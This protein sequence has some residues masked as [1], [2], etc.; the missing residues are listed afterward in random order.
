MRTDLP[1]TMCETCQP[2]ITLCAGDLHGRCGG[3][4]T[5]PVG[6]EV[7]ASRAAHRFAIYGCDPPSMSERHMSVPTTDRWPRP[8]GAFQVSGVVTTDCWPNGDLEIRVGSA[9]ALLNASRAGPEAMYRS[10]G[11]SIDPR[12]NEPSTA[13]V[14]LANYRAQTR[15]LTRSVTAHHRIARVGAATGPNRRS[16][17][18]TGRRAYPTAG[19]STQQSARRG[20]GSARPAT[21]Q[22]SSGP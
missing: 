8:V 20:R 12:H 6:A 1:H 21:Q 11:P 17:Y 10:E 7:V 5:A 22:C 2:D 15:Q 14:D 9:K 3:E 13:T 18:P 4:A 16:R 19:R